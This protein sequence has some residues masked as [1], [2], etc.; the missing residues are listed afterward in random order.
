MS[1]FQVYVS[2][3]SDVQVSSGSEAQ[4]SASMVLESRPKNRVPFHQDGRRIWGDSPGSP[5]KV[6]KFLASLQG[7]LKMDPG[8]MRNSTSVKVDFY[9][10][11]FAKCLVSQSQTSIFGPKNHQNKKPG[12]KHDQIQLFC[13]NV[14]TKLS[15]WVPKSTRNRYKSK[16][17][18][19]SVLSLCSP[20]SQDRP[21]GS[22]D[23]K[24][25]S[26]SMPKDKFGH[27]KCKIWLQ[28]LW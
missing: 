4:V 16:P 7:T 17:G 15:K 27:R 11:S 22:Q 14:P 9:N 28:K 19:Q 3:V 20:V 25:E 8:I 1:G 12:N 5:W 24:V 26:P 2:M 6:I 18:P 23:A 13:S 21:R 10:N